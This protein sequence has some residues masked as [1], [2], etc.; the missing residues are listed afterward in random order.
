MLRPT[1][2]VTL[3]QYDHYGLMIKDTRYGIL[4]RGLS[5]VVYHVSLD[6]SGLVG[7]DTCWFHS[8]GVSYFFLIILKGQV[9]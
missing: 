7:I 9:A 6:N 2:T 5:F 8:S 4:R 3:E 1:S